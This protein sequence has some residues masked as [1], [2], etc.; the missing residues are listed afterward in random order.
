MRS[1]RDNPSGLPAAQL[2][3]A[4]PRVDVTVCILNWNG[5]SRLE[6][7]LR[8]LRDASGSKQI[9][10][11]VIV[12][13]NGSTD[14][15]VELVRRTFPDVRLICNSR[16]V[17][18]AAGNNQA[19]K[20]GRGRYFLLLNNDILVHD[21]CLG[22]MV[23]ELETHREVGIVGGRLV[24]VDGSTQILY[25]RRRLPSLSIFLRDLLWIDRIWPGNPWSWEAEMRPWNV[26]EAS[27][28]AQVPGACMMIRRELFEQVGLLDESYPCSYEDVDLCTRCLRAGWRV[29]YIPD[30]TVTHLG[31]ATF[32][33]MGWADKSSLRFA[34][35]RVYVRKHLSRRDQA[36]FKVMFTM[37]LL[38]RLPI[39]LALEILTSGS[40]SHRWQGTTRTYL[41]V[42]RGTRYDA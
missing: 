31:A 15:S 11:E 29:R 17:G 33:T 37:I 38:A 26:E 21:N 30:A 16:N 24:S 40:R 41:S 20:Q 3:P 25:Y 13:D 1:H 14:G 10:Y 9:H 2:E 23:Q 28:L 22:Q 6:S 36:L 8:S 27:D 7:C 4:A 5:A 35:L 39:V 42:L 34:G 12:V 18:F 19:I 32:K